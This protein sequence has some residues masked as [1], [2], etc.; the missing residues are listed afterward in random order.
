MAVHLRVIATELGESWLFEAF[1]GRELCGTATLNVPH[2][3]IVALLVDSAYRRQGVATALVQEIEAVARRL[4]LKR[5]FATVFEENGGSR[6]LWEALD[7]AFYAKYEKA[8]GV[9]TRPGESSV[10]CN[11][12]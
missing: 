7:F 10:I 2:E 6:K 9:H 12:T 1:S 3:E 5:V 11:Q 8:L 4:G